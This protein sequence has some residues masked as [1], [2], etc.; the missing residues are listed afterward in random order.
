MLSS[1]TSSSHPFPLANPPRPSPA[2]FMLSHPPL[3]CPVPRPDIRSQVSHLPRPVYLFSPRVVWWLSLSVYLDV[4]FIGQ[5]WRLPAT[6]TVP[7]LPT[8]LQ[9]PA[10][11]HYSVCTYSCQGSCAALS[12]LTGCTTRCFEGC[13]CDDHF[14]LSQGVCIPAQ[15]C[16]CVHNGQ[17]VPVSGGGWEPLSR[18][19]GWRD[20]RT[21]RA[22]VLWV[23]VR[24]LGHTEGHHLLPAVAAE[25]SHPSL[26][27]QVKH[28]SLVPHSSGGQE[29]KIRLTVLTPK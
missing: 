14:L 5:G 19:C 24:G 9:C 12:G 26:T 20:W 17:Y 10:H 29:T 15:A 4:S 18:Q 27:Q 23:S 8:A 11:S 1:C 7:P 3:A 25:P 2:F 6:L 21:F 16:G 22:A 28:E 13:E